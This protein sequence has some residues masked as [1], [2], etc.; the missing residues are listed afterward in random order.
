MPDIFVAKSSKKKSIEKE[1]VGE[2][3][4]DDL[5][6]TTDKH[7]L[8]GHTH[9]PLA[10]F[11]Y[12]PDKVSFEIQEKNEKIIL[13]LRKHP[14]TNVRWIVIALLLALAPRLFDSFPIL[15]F[16]PANYQSV[17]ALIWYLVTIAFVLESF[18][19]WFFNVNIITDERII[20]IDF[21][22][23]IYKKVSDTKIENI[24]DVT[25][26]MGGVVR[27]IFNYGNVYIQT[28]AEVPEFEFLA[29]PKPD[30]VSKILQDLV[31]QEEKEKLE[32]R[33]R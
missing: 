16:L 9:N 27:T 13:L 29:V 28:A 32:G 23:L 7:S 3:V 30:R 20:D 5:D 25:Y 11:C 33:V 24:Q 22:N 18:L 12:H 6:P 4:S 26:S 15:S 8:P 19:T 1:K 21:L 10:S 14:I 2:N 17:A 31:V